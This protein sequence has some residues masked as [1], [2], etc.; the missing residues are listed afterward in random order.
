MGIHR[1][2]SETLSGLQSPHWHKQICTLLCVRAVLISG[3]INTNDLNTSNKLKN[4]REG[5]TSAPQD[6][7]HKVGQESGGRKDTKKEEGK[8]RERSRKT[9]LVRGISRNSHKG[10]EP[11]LIS[12]AGSS[13]SSRRTLSRSQS[14]SAVAA[15]TSSNSQMLLKQLCSDGQIRL[16]C[17]TL[18]HKREEIRFLGAEVLLICGVFEGAI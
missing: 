12:P 4:S 5:L 9:Q 14:V 2:L 1:P 10:G 7:K 16:I 15:R 17:W 3:V 6:P 8:G 11:A 18:L 13:P